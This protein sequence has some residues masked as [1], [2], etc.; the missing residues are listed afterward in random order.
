MTH[1]ITWAAL[2][3]TSLAPLAPAQDRVVVGTQETQERLSEGLLA[4]YY[5]VGELLI[6]HRSKLDPGPE[7]K[8]TQ[9]FVAVL[10]EVMDQR[11]RGL[12][13]IKAESG[14]RILVTGADLS[15]EFVRDFIAAQL[16]SPPV[17]TLLMTLVEVPAGHLAELGIEKASVTVDSLESYQ[18]M[19]GRFRKSEK[20]SMVTAPQ[21]T[22]ESRKTSSISTMS[23]VSYV[24]DYILQIVEPGSMEILD[25]VVEVIEEGVMIDVRG[26]PVPGGVVRFDLD[27]SFSVLQ[28]PIP[29]VKTRI[30]S[31]AGQEV[32]VSLPEVDHIK[33]NS[34]ITLPEGSAALISSAAPTE[35]KDFAIIL[36]YASPR[37]QIN[38]RVQKL[39][40]SMHAGQYDHKWFPKLQWEDIPSLLEVAKSK[41]ELTNFPNNPFSSQSQSTCLEGIVALWLIEGLQEGGN[42][43]SLNPILLGKKVSLESGIKPGVQLRMLAQARR[44]YKTWWK[45]TPGGRTEGLHALEGTDLHWY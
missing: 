41:R 5:D 19:L 22:L 25:P 20:V 36:H 15:H 28:R 4:R 37:E 6:E 12:K 3:C 24:S 9:D 42:L 26:V 29:T 2:A 33:L 23:Q 17:L 40:E 39:F 38:P 18:E 14:G 45:K 27:V 13:S 32:E 21:I 1:W 31:G 35:G 44:A 16:S 43:P 8:A 34:V 11:K 7:L 30:R 10:L